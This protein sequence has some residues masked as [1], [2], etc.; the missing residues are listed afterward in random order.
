[1]FAPTSTTVSP[2]VTSRP[3]AAYVS[4]SNISLARYLALAASPRGM[5]I[6]RHRFLSPRSVTLSS[7]LPEGPAAPHLVSPLPLLL[8]MVS[9]DVVLMVFDGLMPDCQHGSFLDEITG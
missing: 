3:W 5:W 4:Y 6:D 8:P 1:M 2:F 9:S 7:P